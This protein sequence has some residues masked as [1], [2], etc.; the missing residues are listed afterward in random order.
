M[1]IECGFILGYSYL[2]FVTLPH[3]LRVLKYNTQMYG[4]PQGTLSKL[5]QQMARRGH[6]N[7][8]QLLHSGCLLYAGEFERAWE[9]LEKVD[10]TGFCK[11]I[12]GVSNPLNQASYYNSK[13]Y[14]ALLVG[15]YSLA[16]QL[17]QDR[18]HLLT[19]LPLAAFRD[20]IAT[21]QYF[22]GELEL[23]RQSFSN[24]LA[25]PNHYA[26]KAMSSYFLGRLDMFQGNLDQGLS[27]L[28]QSARWLPKTFLAGEL[29]RL[30]QGQELI[31]PPCAALQRQM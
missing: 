7:Y 28:S 19:K 22:F 29:N 2:L 23:A 26:T 24:I 12:G 16:Q 20:T 11:L 13:I 6:C 5:E 17:F 21:Y 18:G 15:R 10:E 14:L 1:L 30:A 31:P 8:Y 27:R 3:N 25:V 9:S 4:D